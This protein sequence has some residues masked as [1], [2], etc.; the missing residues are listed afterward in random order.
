MPAR[1][2]NTGV[3]YFAVLVGREVVDQTK[4]NK[5]LTEMFNC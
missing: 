5:L 1:I 4:E 2:R 3:S